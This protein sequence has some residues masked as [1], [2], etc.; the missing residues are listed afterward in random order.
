MR[1]LA[2]TGRLAAV[3]LLALALALVAAS[4]ASAAAGQ[5]YGFGENSAGQLAS[6]VGNGSETANPTPALITLPAASGPVVQTA[7]GARFTLALSASD[8]L[9]AFG[10]N[11]WGQ[12]GVASGSGAPGANP[13][14]VPLTLPGAV[15]RVAALAA[16]ATHSL[17]LTSTGELYTFGENQFGQLGRAANS[18]TENANRVPERISLPGASGQVVQIAAG[19][20]QS[21]A[22]TSTGQLYAFGGNRY[23]ELGSAAN[24]GTPIPNPTPAPVTLPGA[25]GQVVQIAAGIEQSL[26]LTSTGQL[27]AFGGNR[28]GELGRAANVETPVPNPTPAPVSLP[29]SAGPVKSIAAGGFHSLALTASGLI[30]AF[31]R[32]TDG[33]LGSAAGAGGETANATPL[34]VS[35]SGASGPAVGLAAGGAHSLAI[36]ASGQLY[37]FG[38]NLDGQLGRAASS[39][40]ANANPT[41]APVALPAGTTIDTVARGAT[42]DFTLAQAADLAVLSSSLPLGQVGVPYTTYAAA[43]GGAGG[44]AWSA[45]GLPPGL[46]I[47][48]ASGQISGTPSA[49]GTSTVVL[50]VTDV[51]GVSATSAPILLSTAAATPVRAF[52]STALTEAQIRQSLR[53]QLGIKGRQVRI[54]SLRKRKRYSYGFTALTAGTLAIAWYYVPPG[55]RAPSSTAPVLFAA[56]HATFRTAGTKVVVLNLTG[57]GRKLLRHR[58][59]IA[60]LARGTFTPSAKRPIT[61]AKSF[62]LAR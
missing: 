46:S 56:G 36:T 59:R 6:T 20:E 4:G 21:L 29:A 2:T 60:L 61:A 28:Y 37:S 5:L 52:L 9:Y 44:Y 1:G 48:P 53:Q 3:P 41:P 58:R 51:F 43:A 49:P 55:A 27:Y 10:S 8:Q 14:P 32:N 50:G 11:R 17:V 15:G 54:A 16:G 33:Q 35:L 25:S 34:A 42:A 40:T 7:A 24:A 23:G 38:S 62:T 57:R 30:Y 22:L 31:G 39:G 18:G 12:L 47:D 19:A 13:A 26:A 45:S